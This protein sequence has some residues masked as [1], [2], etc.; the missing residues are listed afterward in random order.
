M[1]SG[2]REYG[3]AADQLVSEYK[4]LFKSPPDWAFPSK[5]WDYQTY[6][7]L[8]PFPPT[9][10]FIG[11][12]YFD[13]KVKIALYASAENL[14]HYERKPDSIPTFLCDDRAWNRHRAANS[15]GWNNFFPRVHIGPVE[16]GSLLCTVLFICI[17]LG[18]EVPDNPK[19]FLETLVVANLGKFSIAGKVNKDYAGKTNHL[20]NSE[21]FFREDLKELKPDLLIIPRAILKMKLFRDTI[22]KATSNSKLLYIPQF[23]SMVINFHLKKHYSRALELRKEIIGSVL[24]NWTNQLKGYTKLAPYLYYVEQ[25]MIIKDSPKPNYS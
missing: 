18:I 10:P 12:N 5:G 23:N 20:T 17:K 16:N 21:P 25:E 9:I 15:E 22:N 13:Q 6:P 24:E 4:K 14:A 7:L 19:D 1:S 8:T 2:K 11:K 3:R